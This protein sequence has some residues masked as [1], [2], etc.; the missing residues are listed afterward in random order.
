MS[1]AISGN[2]AIHQESKKVHPSLFKKFLNWSADQQENR[3][4]WQV[5]SVVLFGCVIMPIS[6]LVIS[7]S[8]ANLFLIL[9]A[10]VAMLTNLVMTLTAAPTKISIP[11]FFFTIMVILA[12]LI[13]SSLTLI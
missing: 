12:I 6:I 2:A 10:I 11:V 3:L 9:T 4:G 5:F 1:T 7:I 8:G 13:T